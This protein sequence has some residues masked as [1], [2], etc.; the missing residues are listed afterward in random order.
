LPHR[1]CFPDDAAAFYA[2]RLSPAAFRCSWHSSSYRCPPRR[3]E[4]C[5]RA[6]SRDPTLAAENTSSS[7]SPSVL[8]VG[9]YLLSQILL[10][11]VVLGAH[12]TPRLR[13]SWSAQSSWAISVARGPLVS[14]GRRVSPL[15]RLPLGCRR[16]PGRVPLRRRALGWLL[17]RLGLSEEL[18]WDRCWCSS[19]SPRRGPD[20][21]LEHSLAI[22]AIHF[23]ATST[24]ASTITG[25][26]GWRSPPS[27]FDRSRWTAGTA[28]VDREP[29]DAV[30]AAKGVL[31]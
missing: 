20:P 23:A 7:A 11:H 14:G 31:Y 18:F 24:R 12:L 10:F 1:S 17:D 19:P 16:R 5:L 25:P 29:A 15:T 13:F 30:G 28:A 3:F 4:L 27:G 2:A 8:L 6:T 26:S 9:F 21:L 22:Q